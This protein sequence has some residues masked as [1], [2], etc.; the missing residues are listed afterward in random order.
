M[1]CFRK[2]GSMRISRLTAVVAATAT[3]V[4]VLMWATP[5]ADAA[6]ITVN[7]TDDELNSDG[8]CSLREAITAANTNT[9]VDNCAAG[10]SGADTIVISVSGTVALG[11]PLPVVIE[12]LTINGPGA[13]VLTVSGQSNYVVFVASGGITLTISGMTI[14]DGNNSSGSGGGIINPATST[15]NLSDSVVA[16]NQAGTNGGGIAN[17]GTLVVNNVTFKG[18]SAGS[19]GGAIFQAGGTMTVTNSVFSNNNN[20]GSAGGAIYMQ[21]GGATIADSTF[22][23]NS[24]DFGGAIYNIVQDQD[25]AGTLTVSRSTFVANTADHGG[26]IYN[27]GGGNLVLVNST[28][29][30]NTAHDDGGG[31]ENQD[32]TA[33]VSFSTLYNNV[34]QSEAG[35]GNV[36]IGE[37]G[38]TTFKN[39][40]VHGGTPNDCAGTGTLTDAGGNIDTDG[41]C[42]TFSTATQGQLNLGTL[43]SNG[44]PTQ[45]H[46]LQT[47]SVAIDAAPNCTDAGANS[48]TED[49]R[50]LPR[51]VDADGDTTPECDVGAFEVQVAG[52][53]PTPTS[54]PTQ[55]NT[56][57]PGQPTNTPTRT[58]TASATATRTATPIPE[59]TTL[60]LAP[61][62]P[63]GGSG[64]AAAVAAAAGAAVDRQAKP[65]AGAAPAAISPPNTGDG[66]L[67]SR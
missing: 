45:T 3:V 14:S 62:L 29:S 12:S 36:F 65:R 41:S 53:S 56:P 18:N 34:A 48:I 57:V 7:T 44:G 33:T 27:T 67:W 8:D 63:L 9:A 46:A 61:A 60:V 52:T 38:T 24:A 58:P 6:T 54:T 11:S 35:G 51:P 28:V 39:T 30:G 31:I 1:Q 40:V 16:F 66:G 47:G 20:A 50:G 4:G 22:S 43:A 10:A 64:A 49:Q 42:S 13:N 17:G 26:A 19:G 23:G 37:N 55:T 25:T 32:S 5:P 15:L 59:A 21:D 2:D